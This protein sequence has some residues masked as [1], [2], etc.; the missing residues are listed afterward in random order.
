M[1]KPEDYKCY[2][3]LKNWTE[4]AAFQR[5]YAARNYD[6]FT[7]EELEKIFVDAG[8]SAKQQPGYTYIY[9]ANGDVE[10]EHR[11]GISYDKNIDLNTVANIVL[12]NKVTKAKVRYG[13]F[14][15]F[16]AFACYELIENYFHWKPKEKNGWEGDCFVFNDGVTFEQIRKE[17]VPKLLDCLKE[18]ISQTLTK[19]ALD[20]K[21]REIKSK[22]QT[23]ESDI[24][25]KILNYCDDLK[26]MGFD[27][28]SVDNPQNNISKKYTIMKSFV[29]YNG[30]IDPRVEIRK[31]INGKYDILTNITATND[32]DKIRKLPDDGIRIIEILNELLC[33]YKTLP[34][35][36]V[37][38]NINIFKDV[39]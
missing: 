24:D 21:K 13:G 34:R 37:H 20:N 17:L 8:F 25:L 39:T 11:H 33:G 30:M 23:I 9:Y 31:D 26:T 14:K 5:F 12:V 3:L 6:L 10:T 7:K 18:H 19:V 4:W 35:K 29:G 22:K 38:S 1:K 16:G 15:Y 32:F 27:C 2:E 36:L 28:T